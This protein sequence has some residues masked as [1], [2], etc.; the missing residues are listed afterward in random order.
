MEMVIL[1]TVMKRLHGNSRYK[2]ID[3]N[4][5]SYLIDTAS[6]LLSFIFPMIN[7]I[8]PMKAYELSDD[9]LKSIN[10]E[11][12]APK[13]QNNND[14]WIIIG[15]TTFLSSI[16]KPFANLL[17]LQITQ[18]LNLIICFLLIMLIFSSR[19]ILHRKCALDFP[20][21]SSNLFFKMKPTKNNVIRTL[22]SYGASLFIALLMLA[23]I[24]DYAPNILIYFSFTLFSF[25]FS[26]INHFSFGMGYV[27]IKELKEFKS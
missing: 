18:F 21:K 16:I 15:G 25:I 27:H 11:D 17:D 2:V 4:N 8:R 23:A 13:K 14:T 12:L 5:K 24:L 7:W 22:Y 10:T 3:Y 26:F 20:I 6:Y 1:K 9:E 19:Y